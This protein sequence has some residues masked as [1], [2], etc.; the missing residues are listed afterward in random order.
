MFVRDIKKELVSSCLDIVSL[1]YSISWKWHYSWSSLLFLEEL[2]CLPILKN[3][4]WWS[5]NVMTRLLKVYRE[6]QLLLNKLS[7]RVTAVWNGLG[8]DWQC[9]K[10]EGMNML[11]QG[12]F[13]SHCFYDSRSESLSKFNVLF[14]RES[15][16]KRFS[17]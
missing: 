13:K 1:F 9:V 8:M 6:L 17:R 11:K 10:K 15:F 5:D 16:S 14:C 3:W 7:V 12:S 4:S 2:H